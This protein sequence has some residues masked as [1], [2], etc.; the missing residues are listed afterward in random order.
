[1]KDRYSLAHVPLA[2]L[3]GKGIDR[4]E[5]TVKRHAREHGQ[6]RYPEGVQAWATCRVRRV[7]LPRA[8]ARL[9]GEGKACVGAEEEALTC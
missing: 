4:R 9:G 3:R 5:R 2:L 7:G 8:S 1:M 6:M